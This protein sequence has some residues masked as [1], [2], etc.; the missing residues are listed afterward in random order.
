MVS[1]VEERQTQANSKYK[2]VSKKMADEETIK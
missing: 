2:N 1:G